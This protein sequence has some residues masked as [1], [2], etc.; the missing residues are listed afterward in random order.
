MRVEL[1]KEAAEILQER[2]RQYGT[3]DRSFNR[4]AQIIT[5][6]TKSDTEDWEVAMQM[7][8]VK[9]ARIANDP[10]HRDSYVDA[11]NYLVIAFSLAD[12]ARKGDRL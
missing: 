7:L 9:L 1:L 12:E 2:G 8:G 5:W 3:I 6:M 11:I 4:A 10:V